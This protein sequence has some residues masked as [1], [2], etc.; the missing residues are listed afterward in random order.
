MLEGGEVLQ[1]ETRLL[2]GT[3][4]EVVRLNDLVRLAYAC[5]DAPYGVLQSNTRDGCIEQD[6]D[7]LQSL[8]GLQRSL[9]TALV[10]M[11]T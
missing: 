8:L 3:M 10:P 1:P 4:A 9:G 5:G 7:K 11:E 6:G 2:G